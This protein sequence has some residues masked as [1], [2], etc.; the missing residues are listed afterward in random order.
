MNKNLYRIVFNRALG[1]FQVVAEIAR[2]NGPGGSDGTTA[3]GSRFLATVRPLRF[4]MALAL[5]QAVIVPMA[6]A[7]VVADP[8]APGNQ[9][10]TVLEAAN[11]VPLVNIQTPSAAGVSRNTYRQFDVD[12]QGAILNNSRAN[13]QTELGG[14]VQ[15][16]PWLARGTARVIL[17][18]VNS[19]NPSQLRGY[20]EVAGDRAQLVIANPAGI[21]CDGCGFI[22]ADRSTLTT[23]KP[24][25]NGGSLEGYRVE[26]GAIQIGG[27]GMDASTTNYTDLI[28]RSVQANAGIWA[29]QL[30]V[31]TG[32]NEV[33]ADHTQV[34]K[35]AASGDTPA[36]ALDVGALGGMYSQKIVLV[37]TEHGVGMRNAGT[38]GAGVGQLVVTADGRLENSGTMQARTDTRID[39]SGGLANAGTVSAGRELLVNTAQDIDNSQGT[40][41]ARRIEANAQ[42]LKNRGGA[43]EQTGTQDLVL[44]MQSKAFAL[45]A[46][47]SLLTAMIILPSSKGE[48]NLKP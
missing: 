32:T 11:G 15:G 24:I 35:I 2:R 5:G 20:V 47:F 30:Q 14:W 29:Q 10:P 6:N 27:N 37:G 7:Q 33:S 41:N 9:R 36:F 45:G 48:R 21:S 1:L 34:Q 12:Q 18:E 28:A 8:S 17:N 31:T 38:I 19:S 42:S 4:A 43:I 44:N 40:L 3:A 46:I 25:I 39:A 26:G 23:G 13:T 22:N 16:N